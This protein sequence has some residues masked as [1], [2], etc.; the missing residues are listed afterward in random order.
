MS[1]SRRSRPAVLVAGAARSGKSALLEAAGA[2]SNDAFA[3][4]GDRA[5]GHG[6]ATE[7][8]DFFEL[9]ERTSVGARSDRRR[10]LDARLDGGRSFGAIVYTIDVEGLLDENDE[11][12]AAT[13]AELR[14]LARD[15]GAPAFVA[16]TH[17]DQIYGFFETFLPSGDRSVHALGGA[18]EPRT[19]RPTSLLVKELLD[20]R[21]AALHA[22]ALERMRDAKAMADREAIYA[23]PLEMGWVLRLATNALAQLDRERAPEP[24]LKGVH[25]TS[26]RQDDAW[27]SGVFAV[28]GRAFGIGGPMQVRKQRVVTP[29]EA[30]AGSRPMFVRELFEVVL[31]EAHRRALAL[32]RRS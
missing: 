11:Q 25:F 1:V 18:L 17:V 12:R 8:A 29:Q 16:F 9:A 19:D 7:E 24:R 28:M 6:W 5:F 31:R 23:F 3:P 30:R 22:A 4:V 21:L 13:V 27:R 2:R 14:D 20:R 15:A 10:W 26:A 32:G